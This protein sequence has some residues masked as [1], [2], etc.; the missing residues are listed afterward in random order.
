MM[1]SDNIEDLIEAERKKLFVRR[2]SNYCN[3][4]SIVCEP[5]RFDMRRT[6]IPVF[7][8]LYFIGIYNE[9][10]RACSVTLDLKNGRSDCV[11]IA[12]NA[13]WF[14]SDGIDVLSITYSDSPLLHAL[15]KRKDDC[16]QSQCEWCEMKQ[17]HGLRGGL[18]LEL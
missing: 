11:R 14:A 18:A 2:S 7:Q 6:K 3:D 13:S 15:Y 8:G 9:S 17:S 5:L 12:E 10:K 4:C 16:R 1:L